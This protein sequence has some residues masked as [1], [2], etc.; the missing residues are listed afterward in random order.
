MCTGSSFCKESGLLCEEEKC[1]EVVMMGVICWRKGDKGTAKDGP[2]LLLR[3]LSMATK[4]DAPRLNCSKEGIVRRRSVQASLYFVIH[5]SLSD[6]RL[7]AK[8]IAARGLVE[9]C[10]SGSVSI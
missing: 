2:R 9:R 8:Q 3:G 4:L 6:C 7:T 5:L 10:G 1:R